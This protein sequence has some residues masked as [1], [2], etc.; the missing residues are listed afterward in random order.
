MTDRERS[1][2]RQTHDTAERLPEP[3]FREYTRDSHSYMF[4]LLSGECP[5]CGEA[6]IW[7]G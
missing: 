7:G 6:L 4:G 5:Q 2:C 3:A 1:I